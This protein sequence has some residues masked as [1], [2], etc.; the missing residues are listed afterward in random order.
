MVSPFVFSLYQII[1][2]IRSMKNCPKKAKKMFLTS[3]FNGKLSYGIEV[4]G[5]LTEGQLHQLQLVQNRA[6]NLVL[7]GNRIKTSEKL[8]ELGWLNVKE[9]REKMDLMTLFKMR[10]QRSSPYFERWLRSSRI[11]AYEKL[12]TYESNHG[13][14]LQRSWLIRASTCWNELP[15][16]VRK[17]TPTS[18]KKTLKRHL[19]TRQRI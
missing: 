17:S 2:I 8:R 7:P 3:L 11:P 4:Y 18:F 15:V 12:P 16:E 6:A 14:L 5:A 10:T 19:L 9:T 1:G 13:K